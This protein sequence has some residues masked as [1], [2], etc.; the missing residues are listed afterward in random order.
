MLKNYLKIALRNIL[1]N[2][3]FSFINITGL[4]IGIAAFLVICLF[5][6]QEL[7]FD[8]F[9]RNY[10]NIFRVAGGDNINGKAE[11][12]AL[13]PAPLAGALKNKFPEITNTVRIVKSGKILVNTADKYFYEE[14]VFL[15]DPSFFKVFTFPLLAGNPATALEEPGSVILTESAS[16]KYFG[17]SNPAGRVVK[18]D[19]K[20]NL[21][22][23]GM[24]KD[25]PVNSHF[26]FDFLI[27]MPTAEY[28]YGK[29][30]FVNTFNTTVYTYFTVNNVSSINILQKKLPD[31]LKEYYG[32]IY[33]AFKPSFAFQPLKDIHLYSN[34][35]PELE[36]NG[37]ITYVYLFSGV[38]LLILLMACINYT[39]ILTVR[40]AGRLKE[41]GVRKVLGA[42][43]AQ[44]MKQF[45]GESIIITIISAVLALVLLELFLPEVSSII[46]RPLQI[47]WNNAFEL[48]LM[49]SAVTLLV[50]IISGCYPAFFISAF[51]PSQLFGKFTGKSYSIL[52]ITK[53]LVLLQFTVS[54]ILIISTIVISQQ[55]EYIRNKKLGF[56]KE[57]IVV[58]PLKESSTKKQYETF[59]ELM[60]GNSSIIS[61]TASSVL[62]GDVKSYTSVEWQ[63][64]GYDKTMDFIYADYDFVKTFKIELVKGRDFSKQYGSDFKGS[65]ILNEAAAKKIGW[66]NPLNQEFNS[67]IL[68]KGSVIGIAKDFNYKDLHNKIEPLFIAVNPDNPEYLSI[69]I[70]TANIPATLNFIEKEWKTLFPSSPF[71]YYFFDGHL[72][73]LY[74]SE[75]KLAV[76]FKCFTSLAILISCLGLFGLSSVAAKKRSKEIV[77]R[78][79]MGASI[80][81][82]FYSLTKEFI[83]LSI[84]SV[85]IA[86]PAALYL[87]T[88]WLQNFAYKTNLS[89][90]TIIIVAF[91]LLVLSMLSVGFQAVKAAVANP[92]DSLRNE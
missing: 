51:N 12:Y 66:K 1:K 5:V 86:A 35:L 36:P 49:I 69:R 46:D 44:L 39:N 24:M 76:V 53:Y 90:W 15:A 16:K 43:R 6:R 55:M 11:S 64:S 68:N 74:K 38:G 22:V 29:D 52:S 4:A 27:S 88:K 45:I 34:I 42:D 80:L 2:K 14:K 92:V 23:T 72:D 30:F 9:N 48:I 18:I 56:E 31:F 26:H 19:G 21:K 63:G 75:M 3:L 89:A 32:G 8:T 41:I 87:L 78:K 91:S 58:V 7:S 28:L 17:S 33:D 61:S 47:G 59:K 54:T 85:I 60:S 20:Y 40:Y 57:N 70:N 77:I 10:E 65:Y 79:V 83:I 82:V 73:K 62:P 71:E 13:T 81:N 84:V 25:V 67:C 37:D 50:G